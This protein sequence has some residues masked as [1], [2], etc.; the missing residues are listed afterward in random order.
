MQYLLFLIGEPIAGRT[1]T[2]NMGFIFFLV[3]FFIL[4]YQISKNSKLLL[5]MAG[6]LF[7]NRNQISAGEIF[8]GEGYNILLFCIQTILLTSII[9]YCRAV[10]N[11]VFHIESP[12]GMFVFLGFTVLLLSFFVGYKYLTYSFLGYVFFDREAEQRWNDTFSSAICLSG[13]V[14]FFPA[15]IL[16]YAGK[17]Y[18]YV[19]YFVLIY[20]IFIQIVLLYR[21]FVLFF[22]KKNSSLYFILYLC[23]QEIIPLFL[24]YKGFVYLFIMQKD[25]LWTQI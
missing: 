23:A 15:L 12:S 3:C 14:L 18:S 16:F 8:T 13:V 6:K 22:N 20:F 2:Q 9:V 10:N 7:G 17:L 21:Q 4:I 19:I 5:S 1:Q 25:S 24:L 11:E